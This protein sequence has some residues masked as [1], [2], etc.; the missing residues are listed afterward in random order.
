MGKGYILVRLFK[1]KDALPNTKGKLIITNAEDG[2]IVYEKDDAFDI[3]GRSEFIEVITP[4]KNYR[5]N[6]MKK[7]LFHMAYII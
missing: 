1:F 2:E 7:E 5:N 3:S 4:E 6:H